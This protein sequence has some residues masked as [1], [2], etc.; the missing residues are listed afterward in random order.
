MTLRVL[1]TA[2]WHLGDR[3]GGLDRLPDQLARIEELLAHAE[4]HR[5]DALLVCGDVLE[6]ARPQRLGPIVSEIAR[7]L[8]PSAQRGMQC[9]FLAGNHDSRHTFD[10]LEGLQRLLAGGAGRVHFVG[11]PALLALTADGVPAASLVALPYPTAAAYMAADAHAPTLEGKQA[12]LQQA[13]SD[14][15]DRLAARADSDLPGLP[16]L[17]AGHFLLR[18]APA[19]TGVREVSEV[20]DVRIETP[21]LDD[22]AYVA[23]GHVHEP[24]TLS[25]HVR[26]SGALDR[27]DFGE[28]GQPRHAVLV[29]ISDAGDVTQQELEL[30][31]TPMAQFDVGSLAELAEKAELLADRDHTIVKLDLRLGREDSASLWLAEARDRF[32]RLHKPPSLI[33]LDDPLPA[34]VTGEVERADTGET[35]RRFLTGELEGDPDRDELMALA[36]ELLDEQARERE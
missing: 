12:A 11:S 14:T 13:V 22:F 23:L 24:T 19:D 9:V 26:Y 34:L 16:K 8:E 10:L 33:Q 20:E 15:I 31:P 32:P 35:V 36:A 30:H 4:E 7:L 18:E 5:V 17:M 2:D 27:V 28:A 25:A 6:E 1:H 29:E 21:R 3:L